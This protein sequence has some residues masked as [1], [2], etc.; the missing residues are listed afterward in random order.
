[1]QAYPLVLLSILAVLAALALMSHK[2]SPAPK[3]RAYF[4]TQADRVADAV[5]RAYT[6]KEE[7]LPSLLLNNYR[8]SRP[9][10]TEA[11]DLDLS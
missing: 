10:I 7:D 5:A 9:P 11:T 8:R 2:S 4:D 6:D 3:T 1:M